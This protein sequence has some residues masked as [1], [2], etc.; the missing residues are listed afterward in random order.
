MLTDQ[1]D[2]LQRQ[3]IETVAEDAMRDR[4]YCL[5]I[6]R[7]YVKQCANTSGELAELISSESR[8]WPAL[9]AFNPITGEPWTE[10]QLQEADE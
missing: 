9:I 8:Q 6:V 10:T 5:E 1:M 2:Q 7:A 3:A 4:G